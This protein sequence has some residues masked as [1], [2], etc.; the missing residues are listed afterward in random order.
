MDQK[1]TQVKKIIRRVW[2]VSINIELL[3][4][5]KKIC[6]DLETPEFEAAE[7]ALK[8]WIRSKKEAKEKS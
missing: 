7:E 6:I 1:M 8:M 5:F 3:K 2:R 4:T